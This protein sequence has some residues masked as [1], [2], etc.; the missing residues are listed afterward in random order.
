VLG[1]KRTR[2]DVVLTRLCDVDVDW[3]L[4]EQ[5][6]QWVG[7]ADAS[8]SMQATRPNFAVNGIKAKP[9]VGKLTGVSAPEPDSESEEPGLL[10]LTFTVTA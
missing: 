2:A 4:I 3:P 8:I 10:Q 7:I 6:E 9:I 1:G 5:F